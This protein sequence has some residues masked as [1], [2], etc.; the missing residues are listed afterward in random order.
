MPLIENTG[1]QVDEHQKTD[2]AI[3][4]DYN[5]SD[6]VVRWDSYENFNLHHQ[7]SME[8]KTRVF[9]FIR[10]HKWEKST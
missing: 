1:V 6:P 9:T 10:V 4:V 8:S 7:D 5:T 2:A 3:K